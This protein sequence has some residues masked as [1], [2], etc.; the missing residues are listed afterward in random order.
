MTGSLGVAASP[1]HI[2]CN[3]EISLRWAEI[4]SRPN[5]ITAIGF[6][7]ELLH[8]TL[9]I[10]QLAQ[11]MTILHNTTALSLLFVTRVIVSTVMIVND[12][13]CVVDVETLGY[14]NCGRSILYFL[15]YFLSEF[16]TGFSYTWK[17]NASD[18]EV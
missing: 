11:T 2:P 5:N 16:S 12:Y 4:P 7:E 17:Q 8:H 3:L 13:V 6:V 14:C 15:L 1:R 10:L 18:L 9:A